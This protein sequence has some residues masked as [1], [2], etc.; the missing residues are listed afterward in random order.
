[1]LP[2][3][4]LC[5]AIGKHIYQPQKLG[6]STTAFVADIQDTVTMLIS[7]HSEQQILQIIKRGL[8][9]DILTRLTPKEPPTTISALMELA[10]V[11]DSNFN[12]DAQP[13][14]LWYSSP[15]PFQQ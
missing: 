5:L 8:F 9:S 10:P 12:M 13:T 1:M 14:L 3:Y 11:I 6:E 15:Q 2:D 7:I 4:K